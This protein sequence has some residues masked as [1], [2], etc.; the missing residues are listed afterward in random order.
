[1][2][3]MSRSHTRPEASQP[4]SRGFHRHVD[5][6]V[7]EDGEAV[8]PAGVGIWICDCKG[9]ISDHVDTQR[10]EQAARALPHVSLVRR[11]DTL[12]TADDIRALED[13]IASA[14]VDRLL[15]AGCSARSSL[16]FPE[17]QFTAALRLLEIDRGSFEV[18]NLREQC[19]WLHDDCDDATRKAIDQ[20]RM[21]HARL[22][23]AEPCPPAVPIEP[24]T[25]VI[26]GGTAGIEA[27]KSLAAAG[28][29]VTLVERDTYLGGR[30]CQIG[31]LFQCEGHQAYC[32]SECVGPVLARDAILDPNIE[33]LMQSEV[34]G[35]EKMNGN[36]QARIRKGATFVDA[37]R[38]LSCGACAEVC[39]EETVTEFNRGLYRRRAID[40]DFERAVPDT[41]TIIDVA[42]TRCG[43]CVPVCP[44]D[45]IDLDAAPHLF[46]DTFGAVV[47]G[48]GFDHLDLS[49]QSGLASGADN[50]VTGLD[51]E[52]ILDHELGRPSDGDRPMRVVF[53]LCAGSRATLGK[54]GG[55]VP[56]CSK[57]C[58][59]VTVKQAERVLAK[60]P[61]TEVVI[62]YYG[63]IRTYERALEAWYVHLKALGVE[64]VNGQIEQ[65]QEHDDGN[66]TLRVELGEGA[67]PDLDDCEVSDGNA[68]IETDLLV[69]AAAQVP[70]GTTAP[71]L[72]ELGVVTDCHGFPLENQVR[73]FRPT[74]SMVDRVYAV[75]SAVGPKIVQQ[76]VEQGRAAAMKALPVLLNRAT[77][78]LPNASTINADL[79]TRCHSCIAVCPHGAIRMTPDGA[80][81]DPAFCQ[82]CGFCA[83]ACPTHAAQLLNFSDRHILDQSAVAFDE[84][85]AGE[86]KILALLCY[87]C[88]YS[89][90]DLAGVK[91]L[92]APANFRSIRIRCSSSVNSGLI[93]EVFRTGVDGVLI[94]GC[95]EGGC[96][97]AWGNY[98]S[99][100]RI[101]L[102]RTLFEQLGF[103]PKRLRF[104][105]IGVPQSQLF[106]DTVVQMDAD[107]R[108]LGPNPLLQA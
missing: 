64:F 13:D 72:D 85:P 45:A 2:R 34:V 98:L 53:S 96:H 23:A 43:D 24:K 36:F 91:G 77:E 4:P 6:L 15:F 66:L 25:L 3:V 40:K 41:Y 29:R 87:W 61:E 9:M 106:V 62:L 7:R 8:A 60:S 52:R 14:S 51:F 57:T 101:T 27:A 42:C 86:P 97:H 100:R 90:G 11:V 107:L 46:E 28:Q 59:S 89:G 33:T 94:G 48:T 76:S 71:L 95:P 58:C 63:D 103:S 92:K 18:A 22:V 55:G 49:D 108:A 69:L 56:Y 78:P 82:S 54:I 102:M 73:L 50:V 67:D 70:R 88:S 80:V 39:P 99:E 32:R 20:V 93:M 12:C 1:M 38:C 21:A 26:G 30:L 74:E 44:T 47:L 5:A 37:D 17:E 83:A 31:F 75:G 35:L 16:K 81:S 65:V 79:C 104:E 105:N 19:A 84:L 10:V 68:D